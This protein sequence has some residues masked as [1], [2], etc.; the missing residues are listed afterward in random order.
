MTTILHIDSSAELNTSKSR[1]A[2]AAAVA[3]LNATT[4]IRRD[5]ALDPVPFVDNAWINARLVPGDQQSEAD[6]AILALSDS[7]VGELQAADTIV[8]GVPIY[9]F[10]SPAVLKAW[11]DLVARPQVTFRYESNGPVGLLTGKKAI[12]TAA[13]G[14]V[15]IG[16]PVDHMT[17]HLKT[18]LGFLGITDIT[19]VTAA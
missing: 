15:P 10:G 18:F 7:L 1:A 12:I 14:G 6:K 4:V 13:S 17:A 2:S 19:V 3:D 5:L 16:S 11:M 8:M 9:N